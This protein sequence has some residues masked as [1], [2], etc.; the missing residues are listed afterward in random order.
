MDGEGMT[1]LNLSQIHTQFVDCISRQNVDIKPW[2]TFSNNTF[3]HT[4]S[5][6]REMAMKYSIVKPST[7][8][9]FHLATQRAHFLHWH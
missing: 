8:L 1:D 6:A 5:V 4:S 3:S 9:S 7:I 2:I